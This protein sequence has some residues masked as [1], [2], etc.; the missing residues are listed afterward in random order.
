ML[1]EGLKQTDYF[2]FAG[3]DNEKKVKI[4]LA[5]I[6]YYDTNN[7]DI[8][9]IND[10]INVIKDENI[11]I[12]QKPIYSIKQSTKT[13]H[14]F[15]YS[16]KTIYHFSPLH[17]NYYLR[18]DEDEKLYKNYE[19]IEKKYENNSFYEEIEN[20]SFYEEKEKNYYE[21]D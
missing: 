11:L 9:I 10:N 5:K 2:L 8:E 7:I 21:N 15:I 12:F 19:E 13:G 4:K 18:N 20:N 14:I 17:L 3:V 6:I 1:N 16:N